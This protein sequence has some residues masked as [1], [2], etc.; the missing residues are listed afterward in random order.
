[1]SRDDGRRSLWLCVFAALCFAWL[2]D[3][4]RIRFR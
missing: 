2:I 4:S 3:S 1:V